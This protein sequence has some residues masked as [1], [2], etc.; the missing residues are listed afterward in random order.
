MTRLKYRNA[1]DAVPWLAAGMA[2]RVDAD[3][4]DVV[5]WVPTTARRRR[6]RGFDQAEVLARAVARRLRRPCRRLLRRAAG[7]PQ[8]GRRRVERFADPGLRCVGRPPP[9]V[10]VVDDVATTGATLAW[11]AT[12]LRGAGTVEVRAVTAARTPAPVG[13][14]PSAGRATLPDDVRQE[15]RVDIQVSGRHTEVSDAL[16][17]ATVD[18]IGRLSR[19]VDGMDRAEVHYSE[20]R[21]PRIQDKEICEVT[22]EG[23]GHHV[24]CKVSAPDGFTALDRAV[25]KLE[26]QL[27]KLKTKLGRR[28][29]GPGNDQFVATLPDD[30][31]ASAPRIVKT[32]QF[33]MSTMDAEDALLQ[34]DLLGHDFFVFTNDRTGRAAVVYRREDGDVGLIDQVD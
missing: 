32:K 33:A 34:M 16:R 21:N 25:E 4:V 1:R 11:V 26:H 2:A 23:H 14:L 20:E 17:Q 29:S 12:T 18:K 13:G 5:T 24:R 19:F 27:H 9:K 28:T 31:A 6:D 10:L 8:T 15:E 3:A 22:L 30:A 7:A